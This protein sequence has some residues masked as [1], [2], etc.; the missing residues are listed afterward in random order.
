MGCI[1]CYRPTMTS[2]EDAYSN[3][4]LI[5]KWSMII[6]D[7]DC[8]LVVINHEWLYVYLLLA[9]TASAV[10]WSTGGIIPWDFLFSLMVDPWCTRVAT[11]APASPFQDHL[12]LQGK[13]LRRWVPLVCC[14]AG[15]G[16][17]PQGIRR[18]KMGK[19][20]HGNPYLAAWPCVS[21]VATGD[22]WDLDRQ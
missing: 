11:S 9:W 10:W 1:G 18:A 19:E 16:C 4:P 17:R 20:A 21:C 3:L 8:Q 5:S 13:V 15:H 22:A 7:H 14:C 6:N 2:P 12:K